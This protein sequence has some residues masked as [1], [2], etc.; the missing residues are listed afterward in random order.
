MH[1]DPLHSLI[2]FAN[3]IDPLFVF[4]QKAEAHKPAEV[5]VFQDAIT[6]PFPGGDVLRR[7]DIVRIVGNILPENHSG[8]LIQSVVGH[9]VA[10]DLISLFKSS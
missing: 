9:P 3:H 10:L 6:H 8:L 4:P 5:I 1:S 7:F 2:F